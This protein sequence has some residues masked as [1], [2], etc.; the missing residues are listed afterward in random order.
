M[1]KIEIR[2]ERIV[3]SDCVVGDGQVCPPLVDLVAIA[4][5]AGAGMPEGDPYRPE[6]LPAVLA[7]CKSLA[8]GP[9][10]EHSRM[11]DEVDKRL[12]DPASARLITQAQS[13]AAGALPTSGWPMPQDL[14]AAQAGAPQRVLLQAQREW[15]MAIADARRE[16]AAKALADAVT[17]AI[18]LKDTIAECIADFNAP[19]G[20][21]DDVQLVDLQRRA[22]VREELMSDGDKA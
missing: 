4:Q 19:S 18:A 16:K 20:L 5:D 9:V 12:R 14:W 10:R 15:A 17:A 7:S 21:K 6:L 22:D 3:P 8:R 1:A 2:P 13:Q 11:I